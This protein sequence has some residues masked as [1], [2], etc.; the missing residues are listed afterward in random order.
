MGDAEFQLRNAHNVYIFPAMGLG[1]VASR[2][3]K[4]TEPMLLAAARALGANSPALK[5]PSA[6]LL[7]ALTEIRRVTAEIAVAVGIEAQK[8][9]VAP[10]VSEEELRRSVAETQWTPAY[11]S[12]PKEER[13]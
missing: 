7:P 5:D 4:V 9:G 2:A 6:S 11:A 1:V 10:K 3:R 12:V 13:R 8:D